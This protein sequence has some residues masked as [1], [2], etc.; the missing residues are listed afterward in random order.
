MKFNFVANDTT[1]SLLSKCRLLKDRFLSLVNG[2]MNE[3]L[4]IRL[5]LRTMKLIR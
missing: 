5:E 1:A 3:S 4:Y 2:S